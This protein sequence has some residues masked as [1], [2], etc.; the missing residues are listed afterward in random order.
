VG[1]AIWN[2]VL[3]ADFVFVADASLDSFVETMFSGDF[4]LVFVASSECNQFASGFNF[5]ARALGSTL[6]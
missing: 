6:L 4:S 5:G 1:S 3:G 2:W